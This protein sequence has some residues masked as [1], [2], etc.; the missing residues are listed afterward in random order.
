MCTQEFPKKYFWVHIPKQK[1]HIVIKIYIYVVYISTTYFGK[2]YEKGFCL[3][4]MFKC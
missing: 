3:N 4:K 2:C 1:C